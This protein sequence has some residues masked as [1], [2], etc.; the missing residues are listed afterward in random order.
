[1]KLEINDDLIQ[2]V[3]TIDMKEFSLEEWSTIES[4][5]MFQ[6][7]NISGG[8]DADEAKF[9]FSYYC[10]DG[11]EYWFDFSL[12]DIPKI[13]SGNIKILDLRKSEI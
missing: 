11:N 2:I 1:M 6:A 12:D 4:D 9:C 7:A 10:R 5:D 8:F 13:L 3:R